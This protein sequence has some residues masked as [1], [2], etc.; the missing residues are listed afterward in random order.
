M[1]KKRLAI[2]ADS[3]P[4]PP[5]WFA[6]LAVAAMFLL[7][8]PALSGMLGGEWL[9]SHL[10]PGEWLLL[11][12][13]VLSITMGILTLSKI[14]ERT[15]LPLWIAAFLPG[16]L[17]LLGICLSIVKNGIGATGGDL[18]LAW[19]VRLVFPTLA[20]LPLLSIGK[21]RDRLF[22]ALAAGVVVNVA[23]IFVQ[24]SQSPG[25][26]FDAYDFA[27]A[28][29]FES[30]H[31]YGLY[32]ALALPLIAGWRGGGIRKGRALAMTFCMFLLP[33]LAL[34]VLVSGGLL[35]AALAGLTAAWAV[36]RGHAWILGIFLCLVIMGYGSDDNKSRDRNQRLLLAA[37]LSPVNT[38][39]GLSL[40]LASFD[41]AL[42]VFVDRPFLGIGPDTF[43]TA[44]GKDP[45]RTGADFDA[46][47]WYAQVLGSAGMIGLGLWF[48][49]VAE[50][51]G[52][53]AG[54]RGKPCIETAGVI[55][56]AVG[57]IAAGIWTNVLASG[58]GALVGFML[59]LSI[60]ESGAGE[61]VQESPRR[62]LASDS[63]MMRRTKIMERVSG[64]NKKA[65][66]AKIEDAAEKQ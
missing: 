27:Q 37:T 6:W 15:L 10:S 44:F 26:R 14:P 25:G 12:L 1:I 13:G 30:Q 55:G 64:K 28:G 53:A 49:L 16:A 22:W 24:L 9:A 45:K 8:F 29:F 19:L 52:R 33:A 56:G 51:F 43:F 35:L 57:L 46:P 38:E 21:W 66:D 18:L 54:R 60:L 50:L 41:A 65:E 61:P 58:P 3:V 39:G 59:A 40:R 32:L 48:V 31:D 63:I 4:E 17:W 47:P 36:W 2:A 42:A 62:R 23:A 20:F 11:P 7:P 5:A 34:S